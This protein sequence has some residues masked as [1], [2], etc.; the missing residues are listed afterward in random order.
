MLTNRE[1]G[2]LIVICVGIVLLLVWPPTR[3]ATIKGVP[4]ILRSI[5]WKVAVTFMVMFAWIAGCLA[6]GWLVGLWNWNLLVDAIII[7]ITFAIPMLFRIPQAETGGAIVRRLVRDTIGFAT[8]LEFY[9][10]VEPFPLWAE[11]IVQA[12]ATF[13]GMMSVVTARDKDHPGTARFLSGTLIVIGLGS[14]TWTTVTLVR[15]WGTLDWFELLRSFLLTLWLPALLLPLYYVEA[16]LMKSEML[17]VRASLLTPDRT[18]PRRRV[19][20]AI[21]LGMRLRVKLAARFDGRYNQVSLLTT[22]RE[23]VRFM[24]NF[25]A[26]VRRED[27]EE[28]LR[29]ETLTSNTGVTGTDD[30]GAQLDRREFAATKERLDWISTCEMGRYQGSGNCYWSDADGLTDIIVDAPKHGLPE[31]HG[32]T[33]QTN[34]DGQIWRAWRVLPSGWILGMGGS[35]WRSEWVYSGADTPRS[36]PGGGDPRWTDKMTSPELPV[37]WTRDDDPIVQAVKPL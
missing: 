16:F 37:D 2:S 35:G 8:L 5:H 1:W 36:W 10:N 21:I 7:T 24:K 22:F 15:E 12:V 14:I 26:D 13:V 6:L 18:P 34:P 11:V 29:V 28:R 30:D 19:R 4:G 17:L 25:R 9:L 3:S 20:L 27:G 31:Q 33:V 23:T 32:I